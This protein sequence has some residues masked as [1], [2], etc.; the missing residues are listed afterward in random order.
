[1]RHKHIGVL[2]AVLTVPTGATPQSLPNLFPLP[3]RTGLLET[4]NVNNAPISLT[5]A[6]FQSL[7]SKATFST[8]R[9][10]RERKT[11][12]IVERK[13][14]RTFNIGLAS[15]DF[16]KPNDLRKIEVPENYRLNTQ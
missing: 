8:W 13:G 15:Q 14:H 10:A 2:I 7:G 1:M 16:G 9:A 4:Y 6:F 5:G 11:E 12:N 3:N